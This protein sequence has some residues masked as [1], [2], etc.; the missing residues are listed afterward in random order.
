MKKLNL[1]KEII[2]N[3]SPI[4]NN[5]DPLFKLITDIK[6]IKDI[7]KDYKY[8]NKEIFYYNRK[9]IHKFL[10]E[11]EEIIAFDKEDYINPNDKSINLPE[12]FYL[13][14]LIDEDKANINY[15]YPFEYISLIYNNYLI[16]YKS[17]KFRIIILAKIVLILILNYENFADKEEPV[18]YNEEIE[19]MKEG[20]KRMIEDNL[21]VFKELNINFN[22]EDICSDKMHID[23]LYNEIIISLIRENK[24]SDYNYCSMVIKEL[25]L[26][27]IN[28]TSTIVEGLSEYLKKENIKIYDIN[29][30][31]DLF[32]KS[33][34]NFYYIL[35]KFILKNNIYICQF[36]FLLKNFKHFKYLLNEN[37]PLSMDA[38]ITRKIYELI[39]FLELP[40]KYYDNSMNLY[41]FIQEKKYQF[42]KGNQ[43]SYESNYFDSV[44]KLKNNNNLKSFNN[45]YY[46]TDFSIIKFNSTISKSTIDLSFLNVII[47][48]ILN[49]LKFKISITPQNEVIYGRISCTNYKNIDV[50]YLQVNDVIKFVEKDNELYRNYKKLLDFFSE[51]ENFISISPI[52]FRPR[53]KCEIKREKDDFEGLFYNMTFL[54]RFRDKNNQNQ[55]FKDE[56][57]LE[58]GID[59]KSQGFIYLIN[60]L[61]NDDY[62]NNDN[63]NYNNGFM[64]L[65]NDETSSDYSENNDEETKVT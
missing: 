4:I 6:E 55:L 64:Q 54:T 20:I 3:K 51:I 34:I 16:K 21:I 33:I 43:I 65:V 23:T 59:S 19:K 17:E 63:D 22:C 49:K 56:N 61:C 58:N 32:D 7:C 53:I 12:L 27:N 29:K 47:K 1:L 15:I 26:E 18:Q 10:Y 2:A 37:I 60:E 52:K 8:F 41:N 9:K 31:K 50:D 25:N 46:L 13:S 11:Q 40:K 57:I 28:I 44:E 24:F 62:I 30:L 39:I 38:N 35:Y 5:N 36:D 45:D 14:L 42:I 48:N